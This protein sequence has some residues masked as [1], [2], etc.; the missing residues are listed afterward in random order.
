MQH[1]FHAVLLKGF[2]KLSPVLSQTFG[3]PKAR[4]DRFCP[5]SKKELDCL[6]I[7]MLEKWV[8]NGAPVMF[9]FS[10]IYFTQAFTT[11]ASQNFARKYQIPIDPGR[12]LEPTEMVAE[13]PY[14]TQRLANIDPMYQH[15][16]PFFVSLF[17]SSTEKA[18]KSDVLET[19]IEHL[20]DTF[21]Y[22]LYCY[23]SEHLE[24]LSA[25]AGGWMVKG[26]DRF[27]LLIEDSMTVGSGGFR[28]D[29]SGRGEL[30]DR[31]RVGKSDEHTADGQRGGH[32]LAHFSTTRAML[33][34]GRG[35]QC[36]AKIYDSPC[37]PESESIFERFAPGG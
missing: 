33:R 5:R 22:T 30:V 27:V 16:L 7:L 4:P 37:L 20:N 31:T 19:R 13:T 1:F 23:T 15:S 10:G 12:R 35:E 36:I 26:E 8:D 3:L 17:L 34:K 9:W 11:G 21:R 6:H 32:I 25:E 29:Y 28:T 18:E 14:D 2:E 24:Q